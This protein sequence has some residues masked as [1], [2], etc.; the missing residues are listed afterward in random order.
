MKRL[1]LTLAVALVTA[2]SASAQRLTNPG[3][4]VAIME[5]VYHIF[6]QVIEGRFSPFFASLSGENS[7]DI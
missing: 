6:R 5:P 1:V 2:L 4:S 3:D 7:S